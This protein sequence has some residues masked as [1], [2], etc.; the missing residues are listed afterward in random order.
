MYMYIRNRPA[1]KQ[2]LKTDRMKPNNFTDLTVPAWEV[3]V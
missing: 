2:I 1:A 3:V